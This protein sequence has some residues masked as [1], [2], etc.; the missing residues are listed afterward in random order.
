MTLRC[1]QAMTANEYHAAQKLPEHLAWM[2]CHFSCYGSGLSNLPTNLPAGSMIIIND[3]TPVHGHDPKCIAHQLTA[4][5]EELKPSAFLLDF[6]RE[7]Q[8]ETAAIVRHLSE[9]LPC[10]VGVSECYAQDFDCPVFLPPPPLNIPLKEYIAPWSGREIWLE[11]AVDTQV[12]TVDG[13]GCRRE[14]GEYPESDKPEFTEPE[15]HCRYRICV[16]EDHAKF[17]LH[18]NK[19]DLAALLQE[20]ESLGISL[21]VGLYQEL[22]DKS[23]DPED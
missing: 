19:N 21:A 11:A 10:P 6:Q 12:F 17:T 8:K 1:Y 2:A 22:G 4:L 7:G 16:F 9:C 5:A 14:P 23:N 15:L 13:K 20:A 3:R 18:R